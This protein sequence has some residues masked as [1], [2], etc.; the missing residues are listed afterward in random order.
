MSTVLFRISILFSKNLCVL[1]NDLITFMELNATYTFPPVLF[2][3]DNESALIEFF[4]LSVFLYKEMMGG[5]IENKSQT[6][7]EKVWFK[8]QSN[9]KS[10]KITCECF[11]AALLQQKK[12]TWSNRSD[13]FLCSCAC[14]KNGVIKN[15]K[16]KKHCMA[17]GH[18]KRPITIVLIFLFRFYIKQNKWEENVNQINDWRFNWSNYTSANS[19]VTFNGGD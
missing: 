9:A 4:F 8:K 5:K 18:C 10:K 17:N 2:S 13:K 16:K 1:L 11:Y 19:N 15:E 7:C 3:S 14:E 6:K 12:T